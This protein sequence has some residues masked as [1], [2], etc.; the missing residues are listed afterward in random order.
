MEAELYLWDLN[1]D[2]IGLDKVINP[3][4][5]ER[6]FGP[7]NEAAWVLCCD[8]FCCILDF[9]NRIDRLE[10]VSFADMRRKARFRWQMR[11]EKYGGLLWNPHTGHVFKLDQEAFEILRELEEG[12]GLETVEEKFN[13][14]SSDL[15]KFLATISERV[16]TSGLE[17]PGRTTKG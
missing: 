16:D 14:S 3:E 5:V 8:A 12:V 9:S 7:G 10:E 17:Q 1:Q 11:Q 13:V 6:V 4:D 2:K 15:H